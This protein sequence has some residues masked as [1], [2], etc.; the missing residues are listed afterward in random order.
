MEH[1]G[2]RDARPTDECTRLITQESDSFIGI[3]AHRYGSVP[4]GASKSITEAEFDVATNAKLPRFAYIVDDDAPW[5]PKFIDSGKPARSLARFKRR[6]MDDLIFKRFSTNEGL[7]AAVAADLG[8]HIATQQLPR[9]EPG[10]Q[11][12]S[13]RALATAEQWN[14]MRNDIYSA[15]RDLFLVHTLSPSRVAG[16]L[17]DIFI[18]LR[19]HKSPD[20]PEVELAEFFLGKYWGNVVYTVPNGGG[21]VGL[22]T[23]AYGEFLCVCRVTLK[24]GTQLVLD[25]YVDFGPTAQSIRQPKVAM[26]P[27]S[28]LSSAA[29]ERESGR[30]SGS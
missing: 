27:S 21:L 1:F 2:A 24:D 23:S 3:Y 15:N 30:G 8:R 20:T 4:R 16:Q 22:S 13:K 25:R 28:R 11:S 7:A 6:L 12:R 17:F 19:K 18:Y 29:A 26:A 5:W 10:T 14:R 9:F